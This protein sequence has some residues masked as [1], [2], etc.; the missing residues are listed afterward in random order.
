MIF[1]LIYV[2]FWEENI[3]VGAFIGCPVVQIWQAEEHL[4]HW[5]SSAL[6]HWGY[7]HL[8]EQGIHFVVSFPSF[9]K[10]GPRGT[11]RWVNIVEMYLRLNE[12]IVFVGNSYPNIVAI[13]RA[14][15]GVEVLLIQ[16]ALRIKPGRVCWLWVDQC[17]AWF[18]VTATWADKGG[19]T[20]RQEVTKQLDDCGTIN[21]VKKNSTQGQ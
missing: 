19:R 2:L 10:P 4:E 20:R 12:L 8:F 11:S 6:G 7:N 9:I 16:E 13:E 1:L 15:S 14:D 17:D 3:P 5:A 18:E 21:R